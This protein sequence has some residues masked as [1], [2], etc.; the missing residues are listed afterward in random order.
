[1]TIHYHLEA[2]LVHNCYTLHFLLKK[3]RLY[4]C[5]FLTRRNIQLLFSYLQNY[6]ALLFILV[7]CIALSLLHELG[8]TTQ[9]VDR[10]GLICGNSH[11]VNNPG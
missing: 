3:L 9:H 6:S 5:Y 10:P 7:Y 4:D 8:Y 1:M 11:L 2:T